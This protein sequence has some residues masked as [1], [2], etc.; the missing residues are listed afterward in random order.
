MK[1]KTQGVLI[2]A[3]VDVPTAKEQAG[4]ADIKTTMQIYTHLDQK[5]QKKQIDKLNDFL[6]AK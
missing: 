3:G 2:A 1:K 6:A 4:H 5:Y